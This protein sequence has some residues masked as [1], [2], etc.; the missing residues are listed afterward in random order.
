MNIVFM[1]VC[2][3]KWWRCSVGN[4]KLRYEEESLNKFKGDGN[5]FVLICLVWIK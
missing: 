2:L 3:I 4:F 5:L 1:F